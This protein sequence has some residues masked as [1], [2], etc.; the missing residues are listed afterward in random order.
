MPSGAGEDV[1]HPIGHQRTPD[2]IG[3][4]CDILRSD[5]SF[6]A[7]HGGPYLTNTFFSLVAVTRTIRARDV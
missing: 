2:L 5:E 6:S 7:F 1:A 3:R 4:D